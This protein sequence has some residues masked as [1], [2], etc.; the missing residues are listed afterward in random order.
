M[1]STAKQKRMLSAAAVAVC[2]AWTTGCEPPLRSSDSVGKLRTNREAK[3]TLVSADST[4]RTNQVI[5]QGRI[6]PQR[7]TVRVAAL[8]G[9]RIEKIAVAPGEFVKK[10]SFLFELQ[11]FALRTIEYDATKLKLEEAVALSNSKKQEADLAVDGAKLRLQGAKQS[12]I[13][14]NDQKKLATS[15]R[16]QVVS[17]EKQIAMLQ[18]LRENPLTRAAIGTIELESKKGDLN[19]IQASSEQASLVS[20]HAVE[21]AQMQ[22]TQ[23]HAALEFALQSRQLLESNLSLKS[24]DKQLEVLALQM[25]QG[26]VTSPISGIVLAVNAEIGERTAQLPI[27]ELADL[28]SMVCIAEVH[29]ADVGKVAIGDR[30]ELKS[31]SLVKSLRGSVQRID[32]VVGAVQM[33]SPNPM[34][35]SDFRAVPVWI[36]IDTEDVS[37]AS[38]RLQLQVEV[39]IST[40][41]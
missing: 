35:R 20:N 3:L 13:Q 1:F 26:R 21:L 27:V 14:A 6:Q 4:K 5:A 33:R 11:S 30:A 37:L 19:R 28:T 12:L 36:A 23:A 25:A 17:L 10:D 7:G 22:V 8:P 9:D 34:A 32:R 40:S 15:S 24:L 16:D 31:A 2:A 39:S 38:E 18:S 29:E 41:K